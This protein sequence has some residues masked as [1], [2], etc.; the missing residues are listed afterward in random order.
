MIFLQCY[1]YGVASVL[2]VILSSSLL[3]LLYSQSWI[4]RGVF[5][6]WKVVS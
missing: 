2:S 3:T 1:I 6:L 4:N 5:T